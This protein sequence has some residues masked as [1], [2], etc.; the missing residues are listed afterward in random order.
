MEARRLLAEARGLGDTVP[1]E[2]GIMGGDY[3]L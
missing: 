2:T 1:M 3:E